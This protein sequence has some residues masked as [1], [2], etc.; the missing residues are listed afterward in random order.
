MAERIDIPNQTE[1]QCPYCE[2][3]IILEIWDP[4]D[5]EVLMQCYSCKRSY[6]VRFHITIQTT[7]VTLSQERAVEYKIGH[8]GFREVK[9]DDTSQAH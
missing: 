6:V 1:D 3:T 4:C 5:H 7:I 8:R 2:K 9:D